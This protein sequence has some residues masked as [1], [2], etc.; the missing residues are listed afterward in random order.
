MR[1]ILSAALLLMGMLWIVGCSDS[2]SPTGPKTGSTL[3]V[4]L[5]GGAT[6]EFVWIES[7][8]YIMGSP[9]SDEL[10]GDDE[11]P[12]HEV[13]ISRG[14]YLGKYEVTQAQW[15]AVMDTVPW[16]GRAYVQENPNH[17][18][19]FISWHDVQEFARRLNE[20]AGEEVYRLPTEAEWEY[21]CRAG[22]TTRRSFGDEESRLGEYVWYDENS[23][24]IGEKYAHAV[25]TKLPNPWGLHDMHGNVW[26]WYQDRYGADYYSNSPSVDPQG[27]E[28]GSGR[29]GRGGSFGSRAQFTR[30]GNRSGYSPSHRSGSLGARLLRMGR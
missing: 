28:S 19:V 2:D 8:T 11:K 21:A 18:A 10:A 12:Q 17:P 20:A 7:G 9:E 24:N 27:P 22:T 23:W 29:V 6:M 15:E 25:G 5:R 26:E 4:E 14:F 13:T 16:F 30:S 3:I 1:R